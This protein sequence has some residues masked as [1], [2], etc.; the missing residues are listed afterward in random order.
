M[1]LYFSI[2]ELFVLF[3][4][5]NHS[6]HFLVKAAFEVVASPF[7]NTFVQIAGC[8]LTCSIEILLSHFGD[9]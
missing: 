1:S 8:E 7:L 6:I 5:V 2:L 4:P 9:A 3:Y